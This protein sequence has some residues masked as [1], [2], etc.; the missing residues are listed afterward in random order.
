M[1]FG[2]TLKIYMYK[3]P[4]ADLESALPRSPDPQFRLL[5]SAEQMADSDDDDA[6]KAR[7]PKPK[8]KLSSARGLMKPNNSS[9]CSAVTR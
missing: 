7:R 8:H 1:P 2:I 5:T 6:Y 9:Q 4:R 3:Y